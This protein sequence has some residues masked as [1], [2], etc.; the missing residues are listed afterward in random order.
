MTIEAITHR[1]LNYPNAANPLIG[2][3]AIS[4]VFQQ[5]IV[6]SKLWSIIVSDVTSRSHYAT[7]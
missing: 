2:F 3:H 6:T 5:I 1:I 4:C 7:Y